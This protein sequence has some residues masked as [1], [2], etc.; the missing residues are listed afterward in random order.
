[1]IAV[2]AKTAERALVDLNQQRCV[3]SYDQ[4]TRRGVFESDREF[5]IVTAP[6]HL[7]GLRLTDYR[8]CGEVSPELIRDARARMMV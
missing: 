1:M 4:A 5:V 8:V 6:V 2:L 7:M 3:K